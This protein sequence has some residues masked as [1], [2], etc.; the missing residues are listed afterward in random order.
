MYCNSTPGSLWSTRAVAT[1]TII[2]FLT[3]CMQSLQKTTN[4]F[5]MGRFI[6]CPNFFAC[7]FLILCYTMSYNGGDK[8][9]SK[10]F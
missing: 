5:Y 9:V 7:T 6:S 4:V 8:N 3:G 2:Y 10:G 1:A